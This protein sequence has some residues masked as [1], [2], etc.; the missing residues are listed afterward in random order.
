MMNKI[1]CLSNYLN[2]FFNERAN[3]VS[4]ETGFIKRKRKL[5]GS[6]FIK[7]IILGNIGVANCSIDTMCQL[8]NE[9]SVII[10]KQSLDLR[11]TEEAVEFMKRMYNESM[12]LFKNT[13]QIDCRILQ[14]FKSVKLLDSSYISLPKSL[15]SN[16]RMS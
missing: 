10:T 13:L 8:L 9:A 2:K 7:A 16:S 14:Q 3:E 12:A 5:S 15:S 6:S 4:I 11:F 1:T